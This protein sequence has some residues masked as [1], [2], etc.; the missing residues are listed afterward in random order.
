M[1]WIRIGAPGDLPPGT[2]IEIIQDGEPYAVCNI[3]GRV[4]AMA[5]V[6]PHQGGP[7][8]EGALEGSLVTCPW[9]SWQFDPATGVCAFNEEVR[10]PVYPVRV[11]ENDILVD[12]PGLA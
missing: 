6:C 7:L 4:H 12:L 3:D 5:G 10:I 1:A 9:H 8:G 2:L 11:E